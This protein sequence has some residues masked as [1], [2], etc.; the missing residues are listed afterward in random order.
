[1]LEKESAFW[2]TLQKAIY[3][4]SQHDRDVDCWLVDDEVAIQ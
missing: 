3:A 2:S 4:A 1:V